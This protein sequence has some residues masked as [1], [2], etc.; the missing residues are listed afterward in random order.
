MTFTLSLRH[1]KSY[2]ED[3]EVVIKFA[4]MPNEKDRKD[5]LDAIEVIRSISEVY[6]ERT[7]PVD[8]K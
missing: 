6:I 5:L 2:D 7:E 8:T 3:V 1:Q 4:K